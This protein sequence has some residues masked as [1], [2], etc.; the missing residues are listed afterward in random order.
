MRGSCKAVKRP[1]GFGRDESQ[2]GAVIMMSR[3][4]KAAFCRVA[5]PP[6]RGNPHHV[7]RCPRAEVRNGQTPLGAGTKKLYSGL[8]IIYFFSI[9]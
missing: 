3:R 8:D 4:A 6:T 9:V 1:H 2:K 7:P 5:G